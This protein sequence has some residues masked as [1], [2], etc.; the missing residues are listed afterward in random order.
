MNDLGWMISHGGSK[1]LLF[2]Q[3]KKLFKRHLEV[4]QKY[5]N[6]AS[7]IVSNFAAVINTR[8]VSDGRGVEKTNSFF[9]K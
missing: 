6:M 5:H 3:I 8:S 9:G 7:D 2:K 4:S 1:G